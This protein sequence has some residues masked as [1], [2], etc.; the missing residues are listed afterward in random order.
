[1]LLFAVVLA[2]LVVRAVP[3][4]EEALGAMVHPELRD[5]MGLLVLLAQ[6]N[7]VLVHLLLEQPQ[8]I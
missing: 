6:L 1:M 5:H 3:V 4:L 8:H 2:V 7:Q